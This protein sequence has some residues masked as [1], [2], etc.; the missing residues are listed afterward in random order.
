MGKG[1]S[2]SRSTGERHFSPKYMGISFPSSSHI[3]NFNSRL[4]LTVFEKN[5]PHLI[6][7]C[8][9]YIQMYIFMGL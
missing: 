3:L 4:E 9:P 1:D 5:S 8:I 7:I 2:G 6:L